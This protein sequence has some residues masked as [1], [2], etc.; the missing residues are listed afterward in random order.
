MRVCVVWERLV[1]FHSLQPG[2][3]NLLHCLLELKICFL[4]FQCILYG[5]ESIGHDQSISVL[6]AMSSRIVWCPCFLVYLCRF[7]F[8]LSYVFLNLWCPRL[9]MCLL[10]RSKMQIQFESFSFDCIFVYYIKQHSFEFPNKM[11]VRNENRA[12]QWYL[13]YTYVYIDIGCVQC[14]RI[15]MLFL[16]ILS[17]NAMLTDVLKTHWK[18]DKSTAEDLRINSVMCNVLNAHYTA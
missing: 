5:W 4:F 9:S 13:P 17:G 15:Q 16:G 3:T 12:I 10:F 6:L 14:S 11:D 8:L 2:P 7:F 18:C 1:F